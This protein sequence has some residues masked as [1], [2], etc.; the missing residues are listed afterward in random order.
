MLQTCSTSTA[1]L[2]P[3]LFSVFLS[4]QTLCMQTQTIWTLCTLLDPWTAFCLFIIIALLIN[5]SP[6]R[7]S[8]LFIPVSK[9]MTQ[10]R[11]PFGALWSQACSLGLRPSCLYTPRLALRSEQLRPSQRIQM[12]HRGSH[13]PTAVPLR[14]FWCVLL[15]AATGI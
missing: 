8:W 5:T 15:S 13:I 2:L 6:Q 4:L 1:F 14:L 3:V 10:I 12:Y 7:A 11:D 9:G